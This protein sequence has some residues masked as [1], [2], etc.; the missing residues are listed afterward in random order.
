MNEDSRESGERNSIGQSKSRGQ[1]YWRISR[2]FHLVKDTIGKDF[3]SLVH[4]AC[5]V[6]VDGGGNWEIGAVPD[7]GNYMDC[8]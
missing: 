7:I 8:R 1:E 6:K 5:V 4:I 3:G 2:V